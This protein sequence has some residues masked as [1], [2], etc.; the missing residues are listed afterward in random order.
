MKASEFKTKVKEI[1]ENLKG[2]TIQF[3]TE[4]SV[5]PFQS[6]RE[7]GNAVLQQE[8]YGNGFSLRMVWTKEG[9][10]SINSWEQLGEFFK[11]GKVTAVTFSAEYEHKDLADFMRHGY[12]YND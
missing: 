5:H 7:F 11:T 2:I 9:S 10:Q 1:K 4:Y 6:F 12:K 8:K 3:I